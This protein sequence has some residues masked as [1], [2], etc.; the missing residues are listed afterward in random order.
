[1]ADSKHPK[2]VEYTDMGAANLFDGEVKKETW[3]S[4]LRSLILELPRFFFRT[5][6]GW[7]LIL[8][9]M[10]GLPLYFFMLHQA[11]KLT[12]EEAQEALIQDT[13]GVCWRVVVKDGKPEFRQA[14]SPCW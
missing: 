8:F 7:G 4:F 13:H 10:V 1:M 11:P 2:D 3:G 12:L 9:V 5:P 14:S 6:L